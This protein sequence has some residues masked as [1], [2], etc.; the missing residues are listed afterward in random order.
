MVETRWRLAHAGQ[1]K[2]TGIVRSKKS[3]P[4]S[5]SR[6]T[7]VNT[8]PIRGFFSLRVYRTVAKLRDPLTPRYVYTR[9][10][11]TVNRGYLNSVRARLYRYI[12]MYRFFNRTNQSDQL[13]GKSVFLF[14]SYLVTIYGEFRT[15][16]VLCL[17]QWLTNCTWTRVLHITYFI[18]LKIFIF[19]S[20]PKY[21][22]IS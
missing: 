17:Y 16:T 12:I 13:R 7:W 22:Y 6:K 9:G 4:L 14:R 15:V 20:F 8:E 19:E 1:E 5:V 2:H 10:P 11:Q 3:Y 21:K 18:R